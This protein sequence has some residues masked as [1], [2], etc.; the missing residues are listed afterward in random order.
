ML[1]PL[2]MEAPAESVVFVPRGTRHAFRPGPGARAIV[3]SIR[4]GLLEG[5]FREL[6]EGLQSGHPQA[7][8]GAGLAGKYKTWPDG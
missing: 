1:G 2:E 3:F 8:L 5:F 6:L 4:G 7:Q